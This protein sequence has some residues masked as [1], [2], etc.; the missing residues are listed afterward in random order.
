MMHP[1]RSPI[2]VGLCLPRVSHRANRHFG[3]ALI[4]R[5]ECLLD[6]LEHG[7]KMGTISDQ[8]TLFGS[9]YL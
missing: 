2:G 9:V 1:G 5:G 6:R 4:Y 8:A 7:L 3:T